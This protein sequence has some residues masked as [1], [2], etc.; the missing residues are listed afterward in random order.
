MKTLV[1]MILIIAVTAALTIPGFAGDACC[2]SGHG[3]MKAAHCGV[4][5]DCCEKMKKELNLTEK[6]QA[7]LDAM[8][9]ECMEVHKKLGT[10]IEELKTKKCQLM[11]ADKMDKDAAFK[12][13]DQLAKLNVEQQKNCIECMFKVHALLTPEQLAKMKE[14]KAKCK[15]EA[16][17][18]CDAQKG[19]HEHGKKAACEHGKKAACDHGKK[20]C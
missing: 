1:K 13:I 7:Q 14:L 16:T 4:A 10:Q 20:G 6:Q 9:K 19:H 2:A 17:K 8:K 3:H 18:G 5:G 15:A 12:A 11:C